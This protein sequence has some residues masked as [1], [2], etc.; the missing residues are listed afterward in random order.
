AARSNA[1]A[2]RPEAMVCRALQCRPPARGDGPASSRG[3]GR[4]SRQATRTWGWTALLQDSA[5]H[6]VAGPTHVGMDRSPCRA[7]AW[8]WSRPHAR[9]DGPNLSTAPTSWRL[10]SV[11]KLRRTRNQVSRGQAGGLP[12][13]R[14]YGLVVH[15]L[16]HG[17]TVQAHPL[18]GGVQ[19]FVD[20][21]EPGS[22][23]DAEPRK[24]VTDVGRACDFGMDR[25]RMGAG[26]FQQR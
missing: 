18:V 3:D 4:A 15:R 23:G 6:E 7:T 11:A 8:S 26:G 10:T 25:Y 13:Q 21:A 2:A 5:S 19:T 12:H 22:G 1:C 17:H 24:I 16:R 14:S 20:G 9:G